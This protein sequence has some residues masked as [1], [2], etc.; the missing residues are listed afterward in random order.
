MNDRERLTELA[1]RAEALAAELTATVNAIR[2]AA[3][4]PAAPLTELVRRTL[5]T[6]EQAAEALCLSRSAV[7]ALMGSGQ[8][9]SV[10]IGTRRR[11]PVWAIDAYVAAVTGAA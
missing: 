8:L 11:V 2:T 5:L 1:T 9:C 3:S 10:L 4:A 7:Y 6:V